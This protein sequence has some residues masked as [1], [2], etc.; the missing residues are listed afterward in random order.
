MAFSQPV[1]NDFRNTFVRDF[2]YGADTSHVMDSDIERAIGDAAA[3]INPGLFDT[4][5][6]Y[7]RCFLLLSAHHLVMN[8]RA[9]SQ[10]LS[11]QFSW[12]QGSKGV[13]SVSESFQIPQRIAENP[14]FAALSKTHYGA[15]YIL[16][17]FPLLSGQVGIAGGATTA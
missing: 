6:E 15:K 17:I 4:Q 7:T 3:E 11:G 2:P 8:I 13:G 12:L 16:A 5:T 10:G 1:T 9:S 14:Y